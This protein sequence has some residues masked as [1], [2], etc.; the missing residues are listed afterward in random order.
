MT[1]DDSGSG[2]PRISTISE[3]SLLSGGMLS[4]DAPDE[5]SPSGY[6]LP[7]CHVID[8]PDRYLVYVELPGVAGAG[9]DLEIGG[10]EIIVSAEA[11]N[12]PSALDLPPYV[13]TL[14]LL[15]EVDAESATAEHRDGLLAIEV[16]K[17]RSTGRRRVTVSSPSEEAQG[18]AALASSAKTTRRSKKK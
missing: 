17:V 18:G 13:G 9:V 4:N 8:E 15:E 7:F 14:A 6:R 1:N 3:R 5:T 10:T 2:R 11:T 16:A 12:T